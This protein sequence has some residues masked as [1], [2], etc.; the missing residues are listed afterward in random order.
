MAGIGNR[1]RVAA[2]GAV[3]AAAVVV[4]IA[5]APTATADTGVGPAGLDSEGAY[6]TYLEDKG[7]EF[8]RANVVDSVKAGYLLCLL[9][10]L[11]GA[12]PDGMGSE[13]KAA[14]RYLCDAMPPLPPTPREQALDIVSRDITMDQLRDVNET[15]ADIDDLVDVDYDEDGIVNNRDSTPEG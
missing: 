7:F 5:S 12:T 3:S 14:N 4:G 9:R 1:S 10:Q 2:L 6:L 8:T 11:G 13:M 15:I